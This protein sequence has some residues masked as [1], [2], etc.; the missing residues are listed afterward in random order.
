MSGDQL[1]PFLNV[2]ETAQIL[3]V[4]ANTIRNWVKSGTIVSSRVP[5]STTHRFAREEVLRLQRESGKATSSVAPILRL[6]GPELVTANELNLWATRADA[7]GTFPD[8]MRRLLAATTGITNLDVRA[9]EG[10]AAHGWDG[11]ANS[12]G[13][14]YLPAGALR[15]EFGTNA[16]PKSKAQN[17]YDK[18][19]EA[20]PTDA[21]S[22]VIVATPRNWPGGKVWAADRA[23]ENKFAGVE[24]LDSHRLEGWLREAPPVH[25][26][27]SERL[28]YSP[29][30]VRTLE[31]WWSDFEGRTTIALPSTLFGAGR[32][33]EAEEF[34]ARLLGGGYVGAIVTVQAPWKDDALAFIYDA[35]SGHDDM[36]HRTLLVSDEAIWARLV[37]STSP[38]ILIPL[39][40]GQVDLRAAT[41]KG[42]RVVLVADGDDVVR[43]GKISVPKIDHVA[44][45]E[46]LKPVIA[47]SVKASSMVA[48]GR[49]S[50]PA[51]IRSIAREPRFKAP[52]WLVDPDQAAL[53]APLAL[54]TS[55]TAID[56]DLSVLEMLTGRSR[57]QI[58]LLLKSL[59]SRPDAPFVRSGGIWRMTSPAEAA[60]LLLPR[61]G[62]ED[63]SRWAEIVREVLLEREP[64]EGMDAVARMTASMTGT[65]AKYSETLRKGLAEGLA[66][67]GASNGELSGELIQRTVDAIVRQ[68]LQAANCDAT[69]ATWARLSSALPDLAEASPDIFLDALDTDLGTPD[70]I[71][72]TMF[73]DSGADSIFGASSP[74]SSLLWAIEGLCWSPSHFGRAA[75]I[76]AQLSSIDQG[77][78]L[79]NRPAESLQ[80]ITTAWV[81]QTG[82]SVDDKLAV[83]DR[84]LQRLPEVGWK[85]ALGVW[86]SHHAVAFPPHQPTYRD[87]APTRQ[88]VAIPDWMRFVHELMNVVVRA[89]GLDANRWKEVI[90]HI[91]ELP[92]SDRL[93]IIEKFGEVVARQDWGDE[94]LHAVWG[95]LD[96]ELD[97]H[98]EYA[99]AAW[100][101]PA[102]DVALLRR[103]ADQL[104][105]SEDSRKFSKLFD[106][107]VR[108]PGLKLGDEGYDAEVDYLRREAIGAVLM[109]G[110]EQLRTLVEDV[111]T[112]HVLGYL[113]ASRE[114]VPEQE[115][116]SWLASGRDNLRQAA[117]AFATSKIQVTGIEWL[118]TALTS[119]HLEHTDTRELLMGAVP[120]KREFWTEIASLE[121]DLQNAY[122]QRANP[123]EVSKQDRKDAIRLLL[124]HERRWA[125]ITLL[126]AV[127]H[128][129][130]TLD[131]DLVKSAFYSILES[132]EPIQ[133]FTMS[134]YHVGNLLEYLELKVP[135]DIELPRYEFYFFELLQN[136]HP[137]KALYR[138]L[139][140]DSEDFV[141]MVSAIYRGQNEPKRSLD[142]NESAYANLAW[143]VLREWHTLPG[144]GDDGSIDAA[145]LTEWVRSA[146]LALSDTGRSAI[147]DEQIGHVLAS[148]PIG[149][150]GVWPAETVRELIENIGNARIDAGLAMGRTGRRGV[151]SRG[152]FDGG[153]QERV[154]ETEYLSMA[155]KV[156][157]KWPRTARILRSIADDYHRDA[158][159]N[160]AEA[161]RMG[162]RA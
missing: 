158:L 39:F 52:E 61:L 71:L 11:S 133:D 32:S 36:L 108:V 84:V 5:G 118:K 152:V 92:S 104:K 40:S 154:L 90:P 63:M 113:L 149:L 134:S 69:G 145:H 67:A 91:A 12:S 138:A 14:T 45:R 77:G 72:R 146:R 41:N 141:N 16:D 76:L 75:W 6:D 79:T 18:R 64:F 100:A 22:V 147:G 131:V 151:T 23:K 13:S 159:R 34:R 82:A 122:W 49:R 65:A 44:A 37:E 136:H 20:L 46:T 98:E 21:S 87:W 68:V 115:V 53:L 124:E 97:R 55:W 28:G 143:S 59:S 125:A 83:I 139:G 85:V 129:D 81:P 86:P 26:W 30:D 112:P 117:L 102:S 42:H 155:A 121:S 35:L 27:I 148:S 62:D 47:D 25:Y 107:R 73:R 8:L 29:R 132:T 7:K 137:S 96:V 74:H 51:L 126:S 3:S 43:D 56:S 119:P 2:R 57:Q 156:A 17:D 153:E 48:L 88:N 142:A 130:V 116:V 157:T 101:M 110:V 120:F 93:H 89:A 127:L 38:S 33:A 161:E 80:K 140:S 106:W 4:H 162:D 60:L 31:R 150:D 66:L 99:D 24:V 95:T 9:Y 78:R 58:E 128:D 114:D 10:V 54:A 15:F 19:V 109:L 105:P 1:K 144:Q 103:I 135:E 160:D 123:Y 70:P 50:M 111:K 94:K